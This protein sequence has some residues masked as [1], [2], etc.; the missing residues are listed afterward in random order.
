MSLARE[1]HYSPRE[2]LFRQDEQVRFALVI[3]SGRVKLT[4]LVRA[5][6]EVILRIAGRGELV[7]SI[8]APFAPRHCLTAQAIDPTSVFAWEVHNFEQLFIRFPV[9]Q[10]NAASIVAGRLRRLEERFGTLATERVPQRLARVLLQL[11]DQNTNVPIDLSR[12][13]LA[14]MI[15]TTLFTV[16]RLLCQWTESGIIEP[17]GRAIVVAKLPLLMQIAEGEAA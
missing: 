12:E 7:D 14:Q 8:G 17:L 3:I 10:F 16:S 13:E 1:R 2:N 4:Q 15:G 9:L 11:S 6:K 5:G